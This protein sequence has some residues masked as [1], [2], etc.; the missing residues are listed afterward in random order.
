MKPRISLALITVVISLLS[1][2]G[3]ASSLYCYPYSFNTYVQGFRWPRGLATNATTQQATDFWIAYNKE[4]MIIHV[5]TSGYMAAGSEFNCSF[6]NFGGTS[7]TGMVTNASGTTPAD[8][9]VLEIVSDRLFHINS[10]CHV[11]SDPTGNFSTAAFGST[12]PVD[13]AINVSNQPPTDFWIL[14]TADDFLY[15][16]NATG[17]LSPDPTGNFSTAAFGAKEPRG[18]AVLR[19]NKP[20]EEFWIL[21]FSTQKIYHVDKYGTLIDTISIPT[22]WVGD[23]YSLELVN[24]TKQLWFIA[25]DNKRV[26]QIKNPV[27][28]ESLTGV[29]YTSLICDNETHADFFFKGV[30]DWNAVLAMG[31]IGGKKTME[32]CYYGGTNLDRIRSINRTWGCEV[33]INSS[34][35]TTGK[36][37]IITPSKA[38][39]PIPPQNIPAAIAITT[40]AL[41]IVVYAISTTKKY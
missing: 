40:V 37:V 38:I 33:T 25:Q 39:S 1:S 11:S 8:F 29:E 18:V 23:L 26:Y 34:G 15:H 7:V 3:I 5:N 14:D 4:D 19:N 28:S 12:D 35:L 30:G 36:H 20:V 32:G 9:W 31:F 16:V 13:V 27:L 6:G 24:G 17:H 2:I 21:D 22:D 41:I 10:T